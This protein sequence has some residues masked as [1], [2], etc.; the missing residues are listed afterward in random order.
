[1]SIFSHI[2]RS[3]QQAKEHNAK[4][5]EQEKKEQQKVPYR[6][7]PT[8]AA[9]DAFA[10]AP[11][12]WR[13]VDRP[14]IQEEN[15][16]RSAMAASGHHMNM[17]GVPRIGS[18]SL[19][20]V[21]Y[22]GDD[23]T[24]PVRLSRANSYTGVSAYPDRSR[25]TLYPVPY[26]SYS[27]PASLKGKEAVV[28]GDGYDAHHR[29]SP[30]SSKGEPSPSGS[31]SGSQDDLEM[32]P[33]RASTRWPL[34]SRPRRT[35]D[36][37]AERCA[38]VAK[39]ATVKPPRPSSYVRD[40]RP[41]PSMRGFASIAQVAAP[42]PPLHL[43][44][45][46]HPGPS[47]AAP[48]S[49]RGNVRRSPPS[50]GGSTPRRN[51][52]SSLPTLTSASSRPPVSIPGTPASPTAVQAEYFSSWASTVPNTESDKRRSFE[53]PMTTYAPAQQSLRERRALRAMGVSELE[54]IE[55]AGGEPQQDFV[56]AERSRI[57]PRAV[58]HE[59]LVNIFPEPVS[60]PDPS[61]GKSKK[62]KKGAGGGRLVKKSRWSGFKAAAVVV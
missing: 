5:A 2:R 3:R 20:Y 15:R 50:P 52:A 49:D 14:R 11:P 59:D 34:P 4:L 31:S 21:T 44:A 47:A 58:A 13:E 41:P 10:S 24:P 9:T 28:R 26:I 35:S 40:S 36:A 12:S 46:A 22:P 18:S 17:P 57:L 42:P 60:L 43:G 38:A 7:V 32:K 48:L 8:H 45:M 6:H 30:T 23:A 54:R 29:A 33:S 25:D 61:V 55:S 51:S 27:Q 16:R 37:S 62:S 53:A 39:P 56:H 1:M 19:S